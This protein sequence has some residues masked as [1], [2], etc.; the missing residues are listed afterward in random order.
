M[1]GRLE[2]LWAWLQAWMRG[3]EQESRLSRRMFWVA[4]VVR[5][6]FITVAHKY[7]MRTYM[8][9]FQFGW[10][11]GR[12]SRALVTGYGFAD[13]FNGH[14]GPTAWNPPLYP[15]I[16]A[17]VFKIFGIYT[18]KSGWVILTINSV[19]SAATAP[20]VYEIAWRCCGRETRGLKIALWS[21]W[22]WALFPGA[23]QYAV[24]WVWEMS[25]STALFSWM[26]VLALRVRSVG[27]DD[28]TGSGQ[29]TRQWLAWGVLWGLIGL[30]N[31]ALLAFLPFCGVWMVWPDVSRH[32]GRALRN[33][34]L[35]GVCCAAIISP[36][37]IRN[38]YVFHAFIP[39]R[40]NFGAE[41][42][43]SVL[44]SSDGFPWGATLSLAE[45]EPEFER[46]KKMGEYAFSKEQQAKAMAIIHSNPR[47]FYA[48]AVLRV[49][50][51]WF[52][53]P[54]PIEG[55]LIKGTVVEATRETTYAFISVAAL[56]GLALALRRRMPAA[57]LFF[58]AF[59]SLPMLFYF[60]TVQA[61]FRHPLEPIMTVVIV[62]LFQSTGTPVTRQL[63][64]AKA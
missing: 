18:L 64:M 8:D 49:Y 59:V 43:R 44:P 3:D 62:Y 12:I 11:M 2:G 45:R 14:S 41:F 55:G 34:V 26:V 9:H 23:M 28:A 40:A 10:E 42:Y 60:V 30:S 7:R 6:L 52:G 19:F 20:A 35:S 13:P 1:R 37:I 63:E 31:S 24:H 29:T 32:A 58:W 61:R 38:W 51:F 15:L 56:L 4:F 22:L 25:L 39:M 21:G 57:W 50:F 36:W 47:V 48:H 27:D 16:L 5:V 53:V 54:H 33:V 17:G 46:Y